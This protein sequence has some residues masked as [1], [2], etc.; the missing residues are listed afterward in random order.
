MAAIIGVHRQD[1]ELVG[2]PEAAGQSTQRW[3]GPTQTVPAVTVCAR[4]NL[5][6][7]RDAI[8]P[9]RSLRVAAL[10]ETLGQACLA[11]LAAR[12]ARKVKRCKLPAPAKRR[13]RL[14]IKNRPVSGA[15][16]L[17]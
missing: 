5:N 17:R 13:A 6:A 2:G 4:R 16:L 10:G 11:D 8:Q 15:V 14:A 7:V 9:G 3:R 12:T 1:A